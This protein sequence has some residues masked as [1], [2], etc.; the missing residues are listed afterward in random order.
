MLSLSC[1]TLI[2]ILLRYHVYSIY[3]M[4]SLSCVLY[5]YYQ[6]GHRSGMSGIYWSGINQGYVRDIG[7]FPEKSG[8]SDLLSIL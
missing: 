3:I 1:S 2:Y 4:L 7:N 8:I 5:I 6:G